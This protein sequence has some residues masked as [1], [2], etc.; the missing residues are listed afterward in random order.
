MGVRIPRAYKHT[1]E[2]GNQYSLSVALQ[3]PLKKIRK[4]QIDHIRYKNG[5]ES[6]LK[7]IAETIY[8]VRVISR[9]VSMFN[10]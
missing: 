1:Y 7:T 9:V 6:T 3:H 4:K 2:C 10:L 5:C 8:H